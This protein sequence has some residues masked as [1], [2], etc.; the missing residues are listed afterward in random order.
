[1]PHKFQQ[2]FQKA[3]LTG[4]YSS[5]L[6]E[7]FETDG[8]PKEA[9]I[10]IYRNNY[11][12]NTIAALKITFPMTAKLLADQA[13]TLIATD[14]LYQNPPTEG[15]LLRYGEHF[16]NFVKKHQAATTLPFLSDFIEFEYQIWTSHNANDSQANP[17]IMHN[18]TVLFSSNYSVHEIWQYCTDTTIPP[19]L[20]QGNFYYLIIRE[21]FFT[22]FIPILEIDFQILQFFKNND[23]EVA[24]YLSL[25]LIN[26]SDL[27]DLLA[28]YIKLRVL[29][30]ETYRSHN[31]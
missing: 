29:H 15:H 23:I 26:Q 31:L 28:K 20:I 16:S 2:T 25:E 21:Q 30:H 9:T 22:K 7:L 24:T 14:F 18:S 11:I 12:Q 27:I 19:N 8:I 13:F 10:E 1:M 5:E 17:G 6:T 4:N 3:I